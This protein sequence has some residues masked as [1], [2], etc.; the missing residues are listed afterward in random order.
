MSRRNGSAPRLDAHY[1]LIPAIIQSSVGS[2]RGVFPA[3]VGACEA[4]GLSV[5][6]L[7]LP[8]PA[9]GGPLSGRGVQRDLMARVRAQKRWRRSEHRWSLCHSR[10]RQRTT[11]LTLPSCSM[12]FAG[13]GRSICCARSALRRASSQFGNHMAID[14][15]ASTS[16]TQT[17]WITMKSAMPR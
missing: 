8:D 5:R 14:G 2:V 4:S 1:E 10:R 7:V 11:N 12:A 6:L 15:K 3:L 17:H 9:K 13:K 16:T